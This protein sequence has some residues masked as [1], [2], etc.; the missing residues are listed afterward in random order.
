MLSLGK[1]SND[2][3]IYL[4]SYQNIA[5]KQFWN[6]YTKVPYNLYVSYK[7]VKFF[8]YFGKIDLTLELTIV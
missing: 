5:K 8:E 4:K 1:D 7:F 2:K 3:M 6:H